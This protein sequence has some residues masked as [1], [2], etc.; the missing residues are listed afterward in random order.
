[1]MK[2]VIF[3]F[4]FLIQSPLLA[5]N[6][7]FGIN[8]FCHNEF[9]NFKLSEKI[10]PSKISINILEYK[11]NSWKRNSLRMK[12][13]RDGII[14]KKYKR[15]FPAIVNV[16]FNNK[17]NCE[18]KATVRPVGDYKDHILVTKSKEIFQ[19]VFVHLKSGNINGFT[20]FKLLLTNS[21]NNV[22]TPKLSSFKGYGDKE[23]FVAHLLRN[24]GYIAPRTSKIK[25]AINNQNTIFMLLQEHPSKEMLEFNSRREGPILEGDESLFWEFQKL[26]LFSAENISLTRIKNSNW[27][28]FNEKTF[29]TSLSS[30]NLLNKVYL[31]YIN[32]YNPNNS[33]NTVLNNKILSFN[34]YKQEINL[35]AYD[36][37]IY[38][39][40]A[41]HSLRPHNRIFYYDTINQYFEPIYYDGDP[42]IVLPEYKKKITLNINKKKSVNSVIKSIE[43]INIE[44][45]HKDLKSLG[46]NL[47][48][49]KVK[50]YLEIIKENIN[51]IK[52]ENQKNIKNQDY[53]KKY[54]I[55]LT[56]HNK[57][58]K[59]LYSFFDEKNNFFICNVKNINCN[60]KIILKNVNDV[61]EGRFKYNL[62]P[63]QFL[64]KLDFKD[65]NNVNFL[66]TEF[67][68]FKLLKI[69]NTKFF[70]N[71][72]I[73]IKIQDNNIV[74][75]FQKKYYG[76]V[77][78]NGD[79]LKNFTINFYGL[80]KKN[81]F[82]L[83][84]V[85]QK[86]L[87][88]C[89][90]F[91]DIKIHKLKLFSKNGL[92][93]DSF[94]FIRAG[95]IIDEIIIL[96]SLNDGVDFDF[97]SLQVN[98]ID[99]KN[100]GNDC[101][102][103]SKGKYSFDNIKLN[104]CEDKGLSAG[105]KSLVQINNMLIDN[106]NLAIASKDESE[107]LIN[108]LYANNVNYCLTAYR[109]KEEFSA[110]G[111]IQYNNLNNC[112]DKKIY[113]EEGSKIIKND[114]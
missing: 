88:G 48:K 52:F 77:V 111:Y 12:F 63:V 20:K 23:I 85:D 43:T 6:N 2:K 35:N 11:L 80:A 71:D 1:M 108:S 24:L 32:K 14:E 54:F 110:G 55:N 84:K 39:M 90:T 45:F 40:G 109:K 83:S 99:I 65:K 13:S 25:V 22:H 21:R 98:K 93:E 36:I 47:S 76:K 89:V 57:K 27:S 102:D 50:E 91:I 4:F 73:E 66:N 44:N 17:I 112:S 31:D 16:E 59:I 29:S 104:N 7:K 33:W 58:Q 79:E 15:K 46:S 37:L 56:Q 18:F 96:D 3:I 95:G 106:S 53:F 42:F 41:D 5:N 105:E 97:S 72:G 74:N 64:G 92:C 38:G 78:V 68:K 86:T 30:I 101:I 9:K 87:T 113:S 10:Y 100:S 62:M 19:S 107:V 34:N 75:I 82:D 69:K 94:N 26:D 67:N 28:I 61:L 81:N 103:L 70:F 8:S 60:N 49:E 114:S 51:S